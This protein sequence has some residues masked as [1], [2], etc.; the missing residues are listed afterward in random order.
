MP[1]SMARTW[2]CPPGCG[3]GGLG[4]AD[5]QGRHRHRGRRGAQR[6]SRR[7]ASRASIQALGP[8]A[9]SA[10]AA[11]LAESTYHVHHGRPLPAILRHLARKHIGRGHPALPHPG[12]RRAMAGWAKAVSET[13]RPVA[14]ASTAARGIPRFGGSHG[15]SP[16]GR[17]MRAVRSA[18]LSA[19]A[20]RWMR[21][22][23]QMP[24]DV[25]AADL[26]AAIG[27]K[28]TRC[29]RNSRSLTPA[30]CDHRPAIR[31]A[32]TGIRFQM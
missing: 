13:G 32:Q 15:N 1:F 16:A 22:S 10:I 17:G 30:P 23:R 21:Q 28:G 18:S 31:A 24:Q 9:P 8:I 11:N 3:T 14:S 20:Q 25:E 19:K 7:F 27:G 5:E 4:L 6:P 29:A 2:P 26:V 12:H